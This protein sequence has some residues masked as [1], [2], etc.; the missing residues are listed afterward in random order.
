MVHLCFALHRCGCSRALC[1][2]SPPPK[3]RNRQVAF[4]SAN[5]HAR[6]RQGK[7]DGR[8][9]DMFTPA[10]LALV[11]ASVA[12]PTL[13]KSNASAAPAQQL[14]VDVA[15]LT[16]VVA[17]YAGFVRCEGGGN[18][19]RGACP[20]GEIFNGTSQE[21]EPSG[22]AEA[23]LVANGTAPAA[24][25]GAAANCS[26]LQCACEGRPD[27]M[28][29]NP[30]NASA[31]VVCSLGSAKVYECPRGAVFGETR[32]GKAV[33]RPQ[34]KGKKPRKTSL[35]SKLATQGTAGAP[36]PDQQPPAGP[37]GAA[38]DPGGAAP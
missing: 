35:R 21:C 27:G 4:S 18:A 8:H 30:A 20:S 16:P 33:C 13:P 26:S 12:D 38:A 10:F 22:L 7:Q 32:K 19:A 36:A 23:A 28:Y 34:K 17:A 25:G 15:A 2:W 24:G 1:E 29:S 3:K 31:G 5:D 9:L 6:T 37:S 11:N 14:P